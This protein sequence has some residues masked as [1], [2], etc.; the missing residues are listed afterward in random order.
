MIRAR[1]KSKPGP[2][3]SACVRVAL[4]QSLILDAV[5]FV[6]VFASAVL[7]NVGWTEAHTFIISAGLGKTVLSGVSAYLKCRGLAAIEDTPKG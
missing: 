1:R 4:T 7:G 6:G 5:L 3:A 2:K